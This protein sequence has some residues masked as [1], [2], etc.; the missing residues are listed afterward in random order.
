VDREMG[1]SM[2]ITVSLAQIKN[3]EVVSEAP[4]NVE[5]RATVP[6]VVYEHP[7]KEI[8]LRRQEYYIGTCRL[9]RAVLVMAYVQALSTSRR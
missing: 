6:L 3:L 7:V 2:D 8:A 9:L 4:F 1:G 5:C